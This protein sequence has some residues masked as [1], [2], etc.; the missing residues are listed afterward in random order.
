M[1]SDPEIGMRNTIFD[2][3]SHRTIVYIRN[4][5]KAGTKFS[6]PAVIEEDSATTVI[7]PGYQVRIDNL[8]NIIVNPGD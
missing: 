5:L 3:E 4:R 6:G 1:S 7:P 8:H 2:G